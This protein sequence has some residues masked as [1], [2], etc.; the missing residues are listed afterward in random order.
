M[1]DEMIE[2]P[3]PR[4]IRGWL[5]GVA[6]PCYLFALVAMV[7]WFETP[8]SIRYGHLAQLHHAKAAECDRLARQARSA[9]Q[10]TDA[11]LL[12][13]SARNFDWFSYAY[14]DLADKYRLTTLTRLR[15]WAPR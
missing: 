10:D 11:A 1:N 2:T 9:G 3:R 8:D 5:I 4:R 13:Q 7:R 15:E 14:R 6:V 12:A